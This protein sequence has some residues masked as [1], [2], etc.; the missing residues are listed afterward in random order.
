M[1]RIVPREESSP[2][3]GHH[4]FGDRVW[5]ESRLGFGGAISGY[6]LSLY[7]YV[8]NAAQSARALDGIRLTMSLF[9]ALTFGMCVI[10]LFLYSISKEVEAQMTDEL[11]ARRRGAT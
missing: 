1:W 6:I 2:G 4:L 8:P 9:P 7:G 5:P 11:A 10:R 3:D